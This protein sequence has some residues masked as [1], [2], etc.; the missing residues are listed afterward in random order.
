MYKIFHKNGLIES[1]DIL[2][3]PY[4]WIT[5]AHFNFNTHGFVLIS[6]MYPT[7]DEFEALIIQWSK[8]NKAFIILKEYGL[9][10]PIEVISREIRSSRLYTILK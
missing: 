5:T 1:C 2:E 3:L 7:A 4:G 9:F 10:I 8:V 6:P